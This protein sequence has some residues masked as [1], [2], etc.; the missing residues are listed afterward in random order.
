MKTRLMPPRRTTG[1]A[2]AQGH[3]DAIVAEVES[4]VHLVSAEL[5]A[6]APALSGSGDADADRAEAVIAACERILSGDRVRGDLLR[7]LALAAA[8]M[9]PAEVDHLLARL[10]DA[11]DPPRRQRVR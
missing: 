8:D 10:V 7:G 11:P 6:L 4:I 1:E 3:G 5:R 2:D 9:G